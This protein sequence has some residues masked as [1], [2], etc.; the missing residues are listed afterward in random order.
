MSDLSG[1]QRDIARIA[2]DASRDS[3][4]VLAGSGAIREHCLSHRPTED[5][6]L[7]TMWAGSDTTSRQNAVPG[8]RGNHPYTCA[9]RP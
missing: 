1:A 7:F 6:D 4:F 9:Y 5:I 3:G 8:L 2:L